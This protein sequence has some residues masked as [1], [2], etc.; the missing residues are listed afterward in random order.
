MC[1]SARARGC[2][3]VCVA[4]RGLLVSSLDICIP[5][6]L[7]VSQSHPPGLSVNMK[8]TMNIFWLMFKKTFSKEQPR[9]KAPIQKKN[10]NKKKALTWGSPS[11][12]THPFC[13]FRAAPLPP[14]RVILKGNMAKNAF[15]ATMPWPDAQGP[16]SKQPRV[17]CPD[18][19]LSVRW[20]RWEVGVAWRFVVVGGATVVKLKKGTL[21]KYR[22]LLF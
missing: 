22:C 4:G 20:G 5:G 8:T 15:G 16:A 7:G 9:F 13:G 18:P 12:R 2:V 11:M 19:E 3:C 6:C 14:F 1:A 21:S 10:I 17:Q